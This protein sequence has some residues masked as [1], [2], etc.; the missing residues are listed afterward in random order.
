MTFKEDLVFSE[1]NAES[2]FIRSK[3]ASATSW[4]ASLTRLLL[5]TESKSYSCQGCRLLS[6]ACAAPVSC[7]GMIWAPFAQYLAISSVRG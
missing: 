7:G 5:E 2:L 4:V 3:Y 6:I 1:L